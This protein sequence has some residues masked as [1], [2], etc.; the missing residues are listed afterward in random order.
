MLDPFGYLAC[1][2]FTFE[3][4]NH[5]VYVKSLRLMKGMNSLGLSHNNKCSRKVFDVIYSDVLML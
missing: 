2:F 3:G 1:Q 5:E 4:S